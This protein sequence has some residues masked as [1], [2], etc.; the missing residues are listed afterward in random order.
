M[1]S[2]EMLQIEAASYSSALSMSFLGI[3]L[4]NSHSVNR[5]FSFHAAT[6][7]GPHGGKLRHESP[8][9]VLGSMQFRQCGGM[10][11]G[12]IANVQVSGTVGT[13]IGEIGSID[14]IAEGDLGGR[15]ED[16]R[17]SVAYS[18]GVSLARRG[19]YICHWVSGYDRSKYRGRPFL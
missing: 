3:L 9:W 12:K 2:E 15:Q 4:P 6:R 7:T 19:R 8:Y 18:S 5:S 17:V 1:A 16:G 11:G 10:G 14:G 13:G